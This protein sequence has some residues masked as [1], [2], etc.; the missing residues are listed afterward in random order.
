M[1]GLIRFDQG[2]IVNDVQKVVTSTWS[3][4]TNNLQ[5]A[6]TSSAQAILTDATSSG[7]HYINVY[8]LASTQSVQYALAYGHKA[9][10]GSLDF[11]NDVGS[12]G[13]SPSGN[14]YQYIISFNEKDKNCLDFS[15]RSRDKV[16]RVYKN[17]PKTND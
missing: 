10:S 13:K 1:A 15:W 11:T 9:G 3:D 12:Y 5:V 4:N 7:A 17:H 16:F 2:D 6:Y 14:I 8:H